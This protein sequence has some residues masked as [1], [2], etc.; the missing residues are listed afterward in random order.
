[1]KELADINLSILVKLSGIDRSKLKNSF[2][3]FNI[4]DEYFGVQREIYR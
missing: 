2:G 1:M 3:K 4:R